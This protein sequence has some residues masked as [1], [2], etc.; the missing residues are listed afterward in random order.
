MGEVIQHLHIL[1]DIP[2]CEKALLHTAGIDGEPVASHFD[3]AALLDFDVEDDFDGMT[4][5]AVGDLVEPVNG[6]QWLLEQSLLDSDEGGDLLQP[7]VESRTLHELRQRCTAGISDGLFSPSNMKGAT[8]L[9]ELHAQRVHIAELHGIS[10][11]ANAPS[12]HDLVVEGLKHAQRPVQSLRSLCSGPNGAAPITT[13]FFPKSR[14]PQ[15]AWV[16]PCSPC[17]SSASTAYRPSTPSST[18]SSSPSWSSRQT[19]GGAAEKAFASDLTTSDD[20]SALAGSPLA[21]ARHNRRSAAARGERNESIR[22][23]LRRFKAAAEETNFEPTFQLS[24]SKRHNFTG[25][26]GLCFE[27]PYGLQDPRAPT[28]KQNMFAEPLFLD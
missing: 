10:Y 22:E 24:P 18:T 14:L 15:A 1:D 28:L 2:C 23:L 8:A 4:S 12:E 6:L 25:A 16:L 19:I 9:A 7:K 5:M 27:M 26:H 21:A 3:D 11:D 17:G 20:G 13:G